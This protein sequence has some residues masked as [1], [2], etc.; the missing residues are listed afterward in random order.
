VQFAIETTLPSKS[1]SA[2]FS[3]IERNGRRAAR[4]GE[5][6]LALFAPLV[7]RVL[8]IWDSKH[9]FEGH[10]ETFFVEKPLV[11]AT[12]NGIRFIGNAGP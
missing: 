4:R 8:S 1:S 11:V 7:A 12:H 3:R 5:D 6:D 10:V 9:R 2:R